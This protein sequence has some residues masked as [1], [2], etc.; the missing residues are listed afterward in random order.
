MFIQATLIIA[1]VLAE[2]EIDHRP[3]CDWSC[4]H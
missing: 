1:G 4:E 2:C 3:Y